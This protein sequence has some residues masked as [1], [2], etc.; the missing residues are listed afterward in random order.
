MAECGCKVQ[1]VETVGGPDDGAMIGT[2]IVYCPLHKAAPDMKAALK[3]TLKG[4]AHHPACR[5][6]H[7]SPSCSCFMKFVEGAIAKA[8]GKE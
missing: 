4:A 6:P 3:K 7:K 8:E 5:F 1:G 2:L